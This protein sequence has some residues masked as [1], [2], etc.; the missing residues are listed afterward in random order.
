MI[1]IDSDAPGF[2]K[3]KVQPHPGSLT[4]IKGQ[5]PHPKGKI[6]AEYVNKDNKWYVTLD[7]P[8]GLTGSL[9][10]AGKS[11]PLKAGK[12]SYTL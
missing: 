12:N 10:W 3:I 1:G 6:S 5:M 11:Y 2:A 7:L 8:E 4:N 9:V